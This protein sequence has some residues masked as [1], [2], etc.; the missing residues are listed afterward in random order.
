MA[1]SAPTRAFA[2]VLSLVLAAC[3]GPGAGGPG[4]YKT[5]A[6]PTGAA[7]TETAS[8]GAE[9]AAA[10]GA[11]TATGGSDQQLIYTPAQQAAQR[12]DYRLANA[13][14]VAGGVALERG[15]LAEARVRFET[16]ISAWPIFKAAW[17]GLAETARRQGDRET[18][19]RARFFL[20]R[21]DWI[22]RVH[23]LAAALAFRNLS[24]GRITDEDIATPAYRD[25]AAEMV[26]FLQSADL[27]NVEAAN[28]AQPGE[29]F[30]QRYGIYVAGILGAGLIAARFNTVLFGNDSDS[31]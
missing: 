31:E 4:A 27:A 26:D 18:T 16:A 17:Q 23:P 2:F 30:I 19:E 7:P 9:K 14:T 3:T 29:D 10:G 11:G 22:D 24:E 28:R 12:Y 5:G 8:T 13:E 15:D 6:A 1:Y 20:A 25:Q 21:I